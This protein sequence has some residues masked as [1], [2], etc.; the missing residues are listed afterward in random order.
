MS[1]DE[2]NATRGAQARAKSASSSIARSAESRRLAGL[3]K[4]IPTA[5]RRR[6]AVTGLIRR[7]TG[8][9]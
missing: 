9:A 6:A 2:R 4:Q 1:K 3:G 8:A 5:E 7:T